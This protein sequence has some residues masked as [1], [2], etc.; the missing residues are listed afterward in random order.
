MIFIFSTCATINQFSIYLYFIEAWDASLSFYFV[1]KFVKVQL[2]I[3]HQLLFFFFFVP[4]HFLIFCLFVLDVFC[5][6][7]FPVNS[8]DFF[9]VVF[10]FLQFCS[11]IILLSPSFCVEMNNVA[12][13]SSS[14]LFF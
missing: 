8:Y 13:Q 4:N 5:V 2:L 1:L 12:F 10:L 7:L 9:C 11:S 6:L 14:Y 3:A